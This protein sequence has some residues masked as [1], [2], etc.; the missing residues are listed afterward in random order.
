MGA[1]IVS[2]Q[3]V[4]FWNTLLIRTSENTN[5][6]LE[7][8]KLGNQRKQLICFGIMYLIIAVLPGKM[9]YG[10]QFRT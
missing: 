8:A 7:I 10:S 4:H 1:V 3:M 6:H 9:H 5:S 2:E